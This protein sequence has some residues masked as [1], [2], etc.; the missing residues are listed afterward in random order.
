MKKARIFLALTL[1]VLGTTDIA[2]AANPDQT[3]TYEKRL[4]EQQQQLDE[5][6]RELDAMKA[7]LGRQQDAKDAQD[8]R[9]ILRK[10]EN[11]DLTFSGRLHRMILG[12]DDGA[13]SEAYFTDSEQGPTMLRFDARGRVDERLSLGASIETGI[14]QN[15]P[16]LVSQDN[17][18][19]GTD[20]TVRV[21]EGIIDSSD[22]GK[23][24]FG[25]GFASAWLAPEIDLS[26]TQFAN[27]LPVG[28]LAPGMKFVDASD[29]SLSNIQVQTH[30][31]DVERLLLVDRV[32]YDSPGFGPGLQISGSAAAD[33]RWD[34]ALRAKPQPFGDWKFVAGGSYQDRPFE[35]IDRRW[36]AAASV[37]HSPTG[38]NLTVGGSID[39]LVVGRDANSWLV[40]AG[41]LADLFSIGKT[42][43]TVDYTETTD[44]RLDGD[45]AKSVGLFAVQKWPDFG[46]DFYLGYRVYKVDRPDIDLKDLDVVAAGAVLNF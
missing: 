38:L 34:L 1:A 7:T 46:I 20:V 2:L 43:F 21:A 40:K 17:R 29:N 12:V 8:H 19:A 22:Y 32:R 30:F 3:E 31:A 4:Q 13:N 45:E 9:F 14:R 37:L 15:R 41:W 42:A 25:R 39:K 23:F 35:R 33:D 24:S 5:M 6:Q 44:W 28:M 27:L 11:L 10:N 36:D 18:E 16:F 26:G